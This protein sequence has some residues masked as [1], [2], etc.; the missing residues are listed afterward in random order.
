MG[1][2]G[3]RL[4]RDHADLV[5]LDVMRWD[6]RGRDVGGRL[7]LLVEGVRVSDMLLGMLGVLGRTSVHP[8]GK[9]EAARAARSLYT[10]DRCCA[11]EWSTRCRLRLEPSGP[12]DPL[13]VGPGARPDLAWHQTRRSPQAGLERTYPRSV[14]TPRYGSETDVN[15]SVVLVQTYRQC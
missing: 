4:A 9:G 2:G 12:T 15:P 5:G 14:Q 10:V 1:V 6:G 3:G 13:D 7:L 11:Q 8:G